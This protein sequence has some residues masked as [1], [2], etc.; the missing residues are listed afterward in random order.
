MLRPDMVI[1]YAKTRGEQRLSD[2]SMLMD[3]IN[4]GGRIIVGGCEKNSAKLRSIMTA[5]QRL[6]MVLSVQEVKDQ[7]LDPFVTFIFDT[8]AVA[9]MIMIAKNEAFH[10]TVD[11]TINL[12][13]QCCVEEGHSIET[14]LQVLR[15]KADEV[16]HL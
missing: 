3:G 2:F 5:N 6:G 1:T 16:G 10:S 15:E 4:V 14:G 13:Q 12:L 7:V 8:M 11:Q 9:Q